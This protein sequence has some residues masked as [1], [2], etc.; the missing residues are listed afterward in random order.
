MLM[1]NL[2][3]L[4]LGPT[5]PFL[6]PPSFKPS[7]TPLHSTSSAAAAS[8]ASDY[9]AQQITVLEGLDPVRKRPGMYIGS[10]GVTGLHHLIW[11]VVDNSIDE[12]MGGHASQTIVTLNNDGSVTVS[13]DGRGIPTDEHPITKKSALETVMTVLHAGGKFGGEAS[14]YKVSGGL[15]GVGVSVVNALSTWVSVRVRRDGVVKTMKFNRGVPTGELE[16]V[17]IE[18]EKDQGFSKGTSVTFLPDL[19]VFKGEDGEAS[20][21]FEAERLVGRMDELA[22]LNDGLKM[23]LRDHRDP[24]NPSE[25]EFFH[26]GG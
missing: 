8:A 7:K 6:T 5:H 3:L 15:H 19:E 9:G 4:L 13:D 20:I 24:S 16:T 25:R 18:E 22:Y 14:G 2:L 23:I 17:D 1:L 26:K 12:V 10:T 11:E 21:Q